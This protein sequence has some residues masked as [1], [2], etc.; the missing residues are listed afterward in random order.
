ML[1]VSV[2]QI[3]GTTPQTAA[4]F[5]TRLLGVDRERPTP[6]AGPRAYSIGPMEWLLIDHSIH[7]LRL[8]LTD[9][10]PRAIV[11]LT[12]VSDAFVSFSIRGAHTRSVLASDIG[13]PT[14]VST[15]APGEYARTRLGQTEV[16][17]HCT[18]ESAFDVHVDRSLA[19]H[20]E[21]WLGVQHSA[22]FAAPGLPH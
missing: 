16:I 1:R 14:V 9:G 10:F 19:D 13:A 3:H 21:L 15:A 6:I 20:L 17:L 8:R 18:G 5:A 11:R 4:V 12:D 2:L 22:C 7:D